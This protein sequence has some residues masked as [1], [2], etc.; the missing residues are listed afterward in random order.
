MGGDTACVPV[1]RQVSGSGGHSETQRNARNG[2][3][4][5]LNMTSVVNLEC[6]AA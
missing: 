5:L 2:C 1:Q 6:V 3:S 4:F